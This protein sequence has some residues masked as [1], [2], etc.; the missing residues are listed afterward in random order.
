MVRKLATILAV[1][2]VVALTT[3]S[4]LGSSPHFKRDALPSCTFSTSSGGIA[5]DTVRCSGAE[6]AGLGNADVGFVLSGSAFAT[7]SCV[8]QG[9]NASPGQNRVQF[10]VPIASQT[11]PSTDIRNGNLAMPT[12]S[13]TGSAPN[14]S[15]SQ[16]GCSNSNWTAQPASVGITSVTLTISQ[17]PGTSLFTCTASN[18]NGF[19]SGETVTLSCTQ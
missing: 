13:T 7:Y 11:I 8:N 1:L 18:P 9:G 10:S 14:V 6:L 5:T 16:A 15:A 2:V 3:S 17:P 19:Q 12:L 4:A